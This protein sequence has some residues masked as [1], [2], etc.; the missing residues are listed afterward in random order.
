MAVRRRRRERL[1]MTA[2][3]AFACAALPV[4][5]GA[6]S[7]PTAREAAVTACNGSYCVVG[8]TTTLT[9]SAGWLQ[10]AR[11]AGLRLEARSPAARRGNRITFPVARIAAAADGYENQGQPSSWYAEGCDV[12]RGGGGVFHRGGTVIVTRG[13]RRVVRTLIQG[14]RLFLEVPEPGSWIGAKP[15]RF[16]LVFTFASWTVREVVPGGFRAEAQLRVATALTKGLTAP[17]GVA[18]SLAVDVR[19]S[20]RIANLDSHPSCVGGAA[21]ALPRVNGGPLY[22]LLAGSVAYRTPLENLYAKV[23]RG[24]GC[25]GLE[26]AWN[27]GV[28]HVG[29]LVVPPVDGKTGVQLLMKSF[30]VSTEDAGRSRLKAWHSPEGIH[31]GSSVAELRRAYP[32]SRY[33]CSP[34]ACALGFTTRPYRVTSNGRETRQRFNVA[35]RLREGKPSV[36]VIDV[37]LHGEEGTCWVSWRHEADYMEFDTR[38]FGQ[39]VAARLEPVGAS[40]RF[41]RELQAGGVPQSAVDDANVEGYRLFADLVRGRT[42]PARID[43]YLECDSPY[44]PRCAPGRG[45]GE[46]TWPAGSFEEWDLQF[47]GYS[48]APAPPKA[49]GPGPAIPPMRFV[50]EFLDRPPF[51]IV[52]SRDY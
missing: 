41:A 25:T 6:Q 29:P 10:R 18:G 11:A 1:R 30:I 24:P 35:F 13:T 9:L 28:D 40:P 47:R 14:P 2:L 37:E 27:S 33:G 38:C 42:A 12:W 46:P 17:G 52:I 43:W 20:P 39:L 34:G 23:G 44:L 15:K 5:V 22:P 4:G 21:S 49:S 16:A 8:G 51:T 7:D 48:A 3:A 45:A 31:I 36:E 26:C 50:A 32:D 19:V